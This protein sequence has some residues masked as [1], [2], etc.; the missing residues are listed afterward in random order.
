MP[1]LA[2]SQVTLCYPHLAEALF[3]ADAFTEDH[4]VLKDFVRRSIDSL[5][6]TN[7]SRYK[8]S[9]DRERGRLEGLKAKVQESW[10]GK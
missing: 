7:W 3:G 6:A 4:V 9:I 1:D 2:A 8:K 10:N 5:M